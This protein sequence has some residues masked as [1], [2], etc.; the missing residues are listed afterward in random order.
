MTRIKATLPIFALVVLAA[1]LFTACTFAGETLSVKV[2]GKDLV[3][4]QAKPLSNPVGGDKFKGSNFIHPLKTPSG[5]TVTEANPK[6]HHQ[7]HFGLWWPWK[8]VV[9]DGRKVLCWELQKED[10]LIQ[11]KQSQ[12]TADGFTSKSVYI[13]RK[14]PGGPKTIINET[15]AV[16]VSKLVATPAKGYTLDLTITHEV[17]GDKPL[18]ILKYRYSG[19]AIRGTDKWAQYKTTVLTSEGKLDQGPKV[20]GKGDV[21][22]FTRGKWVRVEGPG[23]TGPAGF[24][25]MSHPANHDHPEKLR[26]WGNREIF[27]NF[28]TVQDKSWIFEPGKKYTRNYRLFVYDGKVTAEQAE[29]LWKKYAEK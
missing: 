6:S 1:A 2:D 29:A 22:N 21:T 4:Y 25:M 26:T 18:E 23:D 28:N 9:V 5:F 13:D 24:V 7:H 27:I 17:V 8:Y 15:L 11:A 10:G 12:P 3:T 14:A 19:F 20:K 16:K